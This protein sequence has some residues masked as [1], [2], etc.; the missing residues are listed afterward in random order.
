MDSVFRLCVCTAR[1][2]G[3]DDL[4]VER[5]YVVAGAMLRQDDE[6]QKASVQCCNRIAGHGKEERFDKEG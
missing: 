5:K 3:N 6:P 4:Y 1:C 2:F